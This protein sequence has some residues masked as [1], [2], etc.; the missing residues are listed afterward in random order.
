[1][2]NSFPLNLKIAQRGSMMLEALVAIVICA[3]GLLGFVGMQA[4]ST[5]AEFESYQRSQALVLIEDMAARINTNRANAGSYVSGGLIGAAL[6]D[7]AGKTGKNLDVCEWG[8]LLFG[9]AETRGGNKV[10]AMLNARGCITKM[11]GVTDRYTVSI[12]WQ[13]IN[14]TGAP[15]DTCGQGDAAFPT[16]SQRRVVSSAVC[17]GLLV[18]AASAPASPRC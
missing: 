10:G 14:Q 12:A 11:A 18:D 15:A 13:G 7:C 8:N 2:K 1:M 16:E 17:I 9:S 5:A 3:F 4:R 6:V